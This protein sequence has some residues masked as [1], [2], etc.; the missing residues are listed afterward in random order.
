MGHTSAKSTPTLQSTR[1][2]ALKLRNPSSF[3]LFQEVT[4][5]V[6]TPPSFTNTSESQLERRSGD[7]TALFCHVEGQ[8]APGTRK[9]C[10]TPGEPRPTVTWRRAGGQLINLHQ[11]ADQLNFTGPVLL[12]GKLGP[13]YYNVT[14]NKYKF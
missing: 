6:V 1:W 8:R 4:L 5:N 2:G 7:T 14:L 11:A 9:Y 3:I 10:I 12:L 13:R